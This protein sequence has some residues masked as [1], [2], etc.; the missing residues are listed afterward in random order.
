MYAILFIPPC[1]QAARNQEMLTV[2]D[3]VGIYKMK[4]ALQTQKG[5]HPADSRSLWGK[6]RPVAKLFGT[7]LRT[8]KYIWNRKTWSHATKHLWAME[9]NF[10][11][12]S[13]EMKVFYI[14]LHFIIPISSDMHLH[15][16]SI[17]RARIQE[18]KSQAIALAL[19][20]PPKGCRAFLNAGYEIIQPLTSM[21]K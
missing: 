1:N 20:I 10:R 11:P 8:V 4:I 14:F 18:R 2:S 7:N 16:R 19:T 3:A 13:F 21:F 6:T 9:P 12:Q 15:G 5:M 17:S